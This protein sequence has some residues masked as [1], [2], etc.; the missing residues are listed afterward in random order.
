MAKQRQRARSILQ[1]KVV[2][3]NGVIVEM[4]IWEMQTN[5]GR[6]PDGLR[7]SLYGIYDGRVLVGYD[8]HYPKG[9]HR[10]LGVLEAPY[11][12]S[13]LDQLKN[14]FKSDLEWQM[15]REGLL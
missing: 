4:K 15:I 2:L 3:G 8:N 11:R 6:Y 5:D 1:T 12:F 10:H 13:S 7:Y 9:H 14:D